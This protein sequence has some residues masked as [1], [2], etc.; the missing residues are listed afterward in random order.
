MLAKGLSTLARLPPLM[1]V[2]L[3]GLT[4]VFG[5]LGFVLVAPI[6]IWFSTGSF[7]NGSLLK[8]WRPGGLTL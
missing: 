4:L 5:F 6:I 7:S 2:F 1:G 8:A 3:W